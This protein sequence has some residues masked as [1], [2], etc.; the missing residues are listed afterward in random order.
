MKKPA[1]RAL[2]VED[3]HAWQDILN[4]ILEDAGLVVDVADS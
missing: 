3:S 1:A 4:E 2:I